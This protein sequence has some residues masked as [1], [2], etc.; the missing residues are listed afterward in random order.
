M[1]LR[2]LVLAALLL[3]SGAFSADLTSDDKTLLEGTWAL[4]ALEIN[5]EKVSITDFQTGKVQ[6]ARLVIKGDQYLFYLGKDKVAF[7]HKMNPAATP[8]EI[9]LTV[10]SGPEKGKAYRGIYKLETDT[11][12]ICRNIDL[13]KARPSEFVTKPRSGL[14]IVVWKR[15]KS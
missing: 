9:D 1:F 13:E 15:L 8:K 3:G 10:R 7:M 12:T 2:T 6:E 11:Y 4:Q 5:G 14:M